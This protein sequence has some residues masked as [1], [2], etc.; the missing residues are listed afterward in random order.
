MCTLGEIG[1]KTSRKSETV[2]TTIYKTINNI[3]IVCS[4]CLQM[5]Y[6]YIFGFFFSI[7]DDILVG[8]VTIYVRLRKINFLKISEQVPLSIINYKMTTKAG[9]V[10]T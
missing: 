1:L 2:V 5:K 6:M 3:N 8:K 7:F 4:N 9:N 10:I